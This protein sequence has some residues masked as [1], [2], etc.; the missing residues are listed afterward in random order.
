MQT[1]SP[2]LSCIKQYCNKL[3][4]TIACTRDA[5]TKAGENRLSYYTTVC[6]WMG[7]FLPA[8][9][10]RHYF[11]WDVGFF[12]CMLGGD[13]IVYGIFICGAIAAHS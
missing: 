13:G 10:P 4:Q 12:H 6:K 3:A 9:N 2:Y 8:Y 5:P 7:R 1:V 11:V